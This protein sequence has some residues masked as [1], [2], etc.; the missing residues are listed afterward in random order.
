M[1]QCYI[2]GRYAN[3][4]LGAVKFCNECVPKK[5]EEPHPPVKLEDIQPVDD[6][7]KVLLP[8]CFGNFSRVDGNCARCQHEATCMER[9]SIF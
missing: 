6:T 1:S 7:P 5:D 8:V 9:S 4:Q 2:C 3:H